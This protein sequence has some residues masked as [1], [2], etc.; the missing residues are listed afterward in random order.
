M[1]ERGGWRDALVALLAI[2]RDVPDPRLGDAIERVSRRATAELPPDAPWDELVASGDPVALGVAANRLRERI[3]PATTLARLE[4]LAA[5]PEDPRIGAAI[6]GLIE[7]PVYSPVAADARELWDRLWDLVAAYRSYP[8]R[9]GIF[10]IAMWLRIGGDPAVLDDAERAEVCRQIDRHEIARDAT[11]AE[12][13]DAVERRGLD[14][15][16]GMIAKR[17]GRAT[18]RD[19]A[20]EA[21]RAAVYSSPD[22]DAP[23]AAY[24]R[25]LRALGDPRGEFIELQL[26]GAE[27]ERQ[28]DLLLAHRRRW[29]EP[30]DFRVAKLERGFVAE[31]HHGELDDH[32][33][34]SLI[35][36][37]TLVFS[38]TICALADRTTPL[39]FQH[40]RWFAA[41]T[42]DEHELA[43]AA[44]H[45]LRVLPKLRSLQLDWYH[46]PPGVRGFTAETLARLVEA[47]VFAQLD[48]L[49]LA[50]SPEDRDAVGALLRTTALRRV[51]MYLPGTKRAEPVALELR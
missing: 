50:V 1:A 2:W 24:A 47:P 44:F 8:S 42:A 20:G 17:I 35:T 21:L 10:E 49:A 27:P 30:F 25:H 40:V 14:D 51:V 38:R 4:V 11:G 15:T 45:Q 41:S 46:V 7:G 13:R 29:A 26:A 37:D 19:P 31:V 16:E 22:D 18:N 36:R 43:I 12:A 6:C 5:L 3:D 48:E 28:R 33:A 9:G 39:G 23:R 34:W 32:P